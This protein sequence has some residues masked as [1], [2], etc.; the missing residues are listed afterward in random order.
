MQGAPWGPEEQDGHRGRY[1]QDIC[2]RAKMWETTRSEGHKTLWRN[3]ECG[4]FVLEEE[5]E[6]MAEPRQELIQGCR[7]ANQLSMLNVRTVKLHVL[8]PKMEQ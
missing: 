7:R 8:P 6:H 5:R 4:G 3:V 1:I 2:G